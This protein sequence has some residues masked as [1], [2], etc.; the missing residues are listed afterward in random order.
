MY[1]GGNHVSRSKHLLDTPCFISLS[2]QSVGPR[3][4][5]QPMTTC[6]LRLIK[7]F[8]KALPLMGVRATASTDAGEN[9]HR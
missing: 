8:D 1:K 6:L 4:S 5:D 2:P 7:P 9:H 3:E